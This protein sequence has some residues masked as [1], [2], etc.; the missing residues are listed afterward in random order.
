MQKEPHPCGSN[1][2]DH[3]EADPQ[4]DCADRV[5]IHRHEP[6]SRL[7]VSMCLNLGGLL[8]VALERAAEQAI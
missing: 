3:N 4:G 8:L 6:T 2:N 5:V 7:L 1:Q